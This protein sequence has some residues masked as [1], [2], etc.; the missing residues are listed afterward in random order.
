MD[1]QRVNIDS[2]P[3]AS[4]RGGRLSPTR[5]KQR[6]KLVLRHVAAATDYP[7]GFTSRSGGEAEGAVLRPAGPSGTGTPSPTTYDVRLLREERNTRKMNL[8]K[9]NV[10][11]LA[12]D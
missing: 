4:L 3:P 10:Q 11:K 2:L 5:L 8:K 1:S 7:H 6:T 9:R 12:A